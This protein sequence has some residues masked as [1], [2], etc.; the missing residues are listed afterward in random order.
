M[1]SLCKKIKNF[2]LGNIDLAL[3]NYI[4]DHYFFSVL[5]NK[6]YKIKKNQYNID[7]IVVSGNSFCSG[8]VYKYIIIHCKDNTFKVYCIEKTN[9]YWILKDL[10]VKNNKIIEYNIG[11]LPKVKESQME[12]IYDSYNNLT[13]NVNNL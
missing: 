10:K 3:L 11:L 4:Q 6:F 8:D 5:P 12:L 7:L 13:V 2:F 9:I 1:S